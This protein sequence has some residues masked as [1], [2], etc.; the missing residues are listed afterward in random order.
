MVGLLALGAAGLGCTPRLRAGQRCAARRG[1]VGAA[2][3]RTWRGAGARKRSSMPAD[4]SMS[5]LLAGASAAATPASPCGSPVPAAASA[6]PAAAA[7]SAGCAASSAAASAG[8]PPPT[9]TRRAASAASA[10]P[11]AAGAHCHR[12]RGA[13]S[14]LARQRPA[15]TR[16]VL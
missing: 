2:P 12:S 14:W 13:S 11:S 15:T 4:S 7:H 6:S 3:S 16:P 9:G 10:A 8:A 5:G 1:S